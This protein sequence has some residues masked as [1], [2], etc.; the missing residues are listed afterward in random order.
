[1]VV[2]VTIEMAQQGACA[3]SGVDVCCGVAEYGSHAGAHV[4][5]VCGEGGSVDVLE[6]RLE[7]L[8]SH[9]DLLL[10]ILGR[11]GDVLLPLAMACVGGVV[12]VR[13][14]V[15][16]QVEY[17]FEAGCGLVDVIGGVVVAPP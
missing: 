8:E 10:D 13:G 1:V 11:L 17:V 16:Q 15:S 14:E 4:I 9:A 7:V 12:E 5:G 3:V 2:G 6:H